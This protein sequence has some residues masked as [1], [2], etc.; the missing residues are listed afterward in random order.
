MLFKLP[1]VFCLFILK[2][3]HFSPRIPFW[4]SG[5]KGVCVL[6]SPLFKPNTQLP[7]VTHKDNV[8]G[9]GILQKYHRAAVKYKPVKLWSQKWLFHKLGCSLPTVL[10][11]ADWQILRYTSYVQRY[12]RLLK[13]E[14]LIY[15]LH[16]TCIVILLLPIISIITV[17][18]PCGC[19]FL[20]LSHL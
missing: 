18:L 8:W 5:L 17:Y 14:F 9:W 16:C 7:L 20:N 2:L 10:A 4:V 11:A 3:S 6:Q 19:L 13:W 15:F 1:S 12:C